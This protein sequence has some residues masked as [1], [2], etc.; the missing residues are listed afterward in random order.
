LLSLAKTR[1]R[2]GALAAGLRAVLRPTARPPRGD[3]GG[4]PCTP[5]D[6]TP[7]KRPGQP[8]PSGCPPQRSRSWFAYPT[9][10]RA[11]PPHGGPMRRWTA[12]TSCEEMLAGSGSA[13]TVAPAWG[14]PARGTT[15]ERR[16]GRVSAPLTVSA[17]RLAASVTYA[18][19]G[20]FPPSIHPVGNRSQSLS[21]T[22]WVSLKQM[23]P[24]N[25]FEIGASVGR[26]CGV[27]L[28]PSMISVNR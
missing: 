3:K 15:S 16:E 23:M 28:T 22:C 5:G 4:E 9:D 13:A 18:R 1:R 6:A 11:F 12:M 21:C 8:G 24:S 10:C 27:W 26:P 2:E 25:V 7:F 19:L 20:H 14:G 17:A